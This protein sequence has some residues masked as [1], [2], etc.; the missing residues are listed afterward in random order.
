VIDS[1]YVG[2]HLK[3]H[4]QVPLFFPSSAAGVS[5]KEVATALGPDALREP[6]GPLPADSSQDANLPVELQDLKREAERRFNEWAT[7]GRGLISSSLYDAAAWFST[8]LG[9]LHSHD[10]QIACIP[11]GYTL[12]LWNALLRVDASQFFDNA[13]QR[14]SAEAQSMIILANP[15]LPHSEGE[16]LIESADPAVHP[17]IRM[18]YY[19]DP[20]DLKV[21][22]AA[23]RRAFDIVE[24]WPGRQRIGAWLAPPFLAAKHGHQQGSRPDDAL[25]EDLALHFSITV[26]HLTGTCRIGDVVD[27]QLRVRDVRGLRVADASVMP[28]LVSGNTNAASVMVGEKAAEMIAA[29]HGIKLSGFVGAMSKRQSSA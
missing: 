5:M 27:P 12:E 17:D 18:N 2:K 11:C 16:I 22:V 19:A 4:V 15:V 9:D 7:T 1:P 13:A 29:D 10:V 24:H 3:D 20:H 6:A 26:Y 14:L 21:M 23:L 25:L 28:N 8:G